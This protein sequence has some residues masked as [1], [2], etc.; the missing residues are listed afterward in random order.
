MAE[1]GSNNPTV[2]ETGS[3]TAVE[4]KAYP[5]RFY[6][7]VVT[8]LLAVC[9]NIAWLTFGPVPDQAKRRY[10]LTDAEL[11]LLTGTDVNSNGRRRTC[12]KPTVP[13]LEGQ[14]LLVRTF[15]NCW[16][17]IWKCPTFCSTSQVGTNARLVHMLVSRLQ[18]C[19]QIYSFVWGPDFS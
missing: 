7:L 9:Q 8:A 6:V 2:Q 1:S 15:C 10:G 3:K 19:Q 18:C 17:H 4:Y 5:G 14:S 16:F 12:D 11:T 13:I